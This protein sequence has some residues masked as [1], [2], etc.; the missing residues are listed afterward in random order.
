MSQSLL[1][2][3]AVMLAATGIAGAISVATAQPGAANPWAAVGDS[4]LAGAITAIEANTGGRVLEI[5]VRLR[6]RSRQASPQPP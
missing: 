1:G 2:A 6:S 3:A 5:R 4:S